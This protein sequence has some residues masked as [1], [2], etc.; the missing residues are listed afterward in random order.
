MGDVTLLNDNISFPS[1]YMSVKLIMRNAYVFLISSLLLELF[2][3]G[4]KMK[5]KF[6]RELT[7][8]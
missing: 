8:I 2:L 3:L 7:C 6:N 4:G 5:D 1:S